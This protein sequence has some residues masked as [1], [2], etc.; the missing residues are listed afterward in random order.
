MSTSYLLTANDQIRGFDEAGSL[1]GTIDIEYP[2]GAY[3]A[4]EHARDIVMLAGGNIA[5]YN[6]TFDPY[7]SIYNAT[8]SSW[9]HHTMPGFSTVN[10]VSYGG[11]DVLGN[12]I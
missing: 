4:T 12:N 6:G 9:S 2:A 11:I 7:L 5:V 10:N 1:T 8:T 3:P